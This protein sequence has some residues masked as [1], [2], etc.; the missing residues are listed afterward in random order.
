MV[1]LYQL[2]DIYLGEGIGARF[3]GA[4]TGLFCDSRILTKFW[5]SLSVIPENSLLTNSLRLLIIL[6]LYLFF[7]DIASNIIKETS[8]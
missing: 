2:S 7:P 6:L 8:P 1:I 5:T 3:L 4:G